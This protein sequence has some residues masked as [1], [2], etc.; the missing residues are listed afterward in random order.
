MES[1]SG[2]QSSK[3]C[4]KNQPK[5]S[6]EEIDKK[7]DKRRVALVSQ[8]ENF[9]ST[10]EMFKNREVGVEFS[11][12]GISSLVCFVEVGDEKFVLK[13]ALNDTVSDGSE[14]LFLK[15]WEIAGVKTPHIFKE[16]EF[17]GGPYVLMEYISAP[18]AEA[19]YKDGEIAKEDM[20][21]EAGKILRDMHK[22]ES[23]GFGKVI[24]GKGEYAS[25]N[26]WIDSPDMEK[27]VRYVEDNNLLSL[28]H[29]DFS[30]ARDILVDYVGGSNKSSYCHF[31]FGAGHL[32]ATEPLTVF[33]PNPLFNNGYIDLGRTLVNYIAATGSY[34]QKIVDGYSREVRLDEKVLHAAIFINIV[35]KMPYQ[36]QKG[37]I[38]VIQNFQNYLVKNKI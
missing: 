36:H 9:L 11:H 4:F 23:T 21:F 28:E 10:D 5:L 8:V 30:H 18:T 29:G 35:Y 20:Y 16:G 17:V 32:F 27:R 31:D 14:A 15:T 12:E 2:K 25:F 19:K 24:D 13:I 3:V 33:D 6:G 7:R 22:P 1:N 37:K 26:E 34:P 38:Q